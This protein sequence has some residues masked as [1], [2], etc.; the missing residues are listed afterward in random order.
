MPTPPRRAPERENRRAAARLEADAPARLAG[1]ASSLEGRLENVSATGVA[2]LTSTI[3]P[4]I[5]IGTQVVV[6]A[7]GLGENGADREFRG[8]IV[9]T[10]TLFD[11][12]GEVR[13]YAVT[14]GE[15]GTG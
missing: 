12:T 8:R 10:E 7:S 9:R 13:M 3:E 11:V 14:F 1:G 2:F 15:G 6:V 5:P 4:E